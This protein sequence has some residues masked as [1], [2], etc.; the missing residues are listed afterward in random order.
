MPCSDWSEYDRVATPELRV[1]EDEV[2]RLREKTD[3]L[4]RHLC[5]ACEVV[6]R[7]SAT[8][9]PRDLMGWWEQHKMDAE[10]RRQEVRRA[11]LAKLT[12]EERELLGLTT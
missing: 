6:E 9:W 11:A 10:R 2:T 3:F 4:T 12:P 7:D 5:W 8:A 1:S